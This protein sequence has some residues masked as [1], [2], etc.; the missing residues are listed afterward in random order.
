[1]LVIPV[2]PAI[3]VIVASLIAA[4]TDIWNYKVYNVLTLPLLVTGLIYNA[5]IGGWAGL[6][7]SGMGLL[8]GF[9][10]LLLFYS[11]GGMGAGDVKLMAAIGAW[12]GMPLT[13][14]IF[15]ASALAGG[16][17]AVFLLIFTT[18]LQD[19]IIHM[20]IL[21]LRVKAFSRH[22]APDTKIE[23]E[24]K[25]VDRRKRL[26]PFAAMMAIG[27]VAVVTYVWTHSEPSRNSSV[28]GLPR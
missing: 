26:I 27:V 4:A 3:V 1:M 14:Y 5:V 13:L 18:G 11:L 8:F 10:A 25:R 6:A 2:F 22:F 23:V 16:I 20:H 17:Y 7:N 21:W 15:V 28:V 24:V 12:L 19:S 9:L